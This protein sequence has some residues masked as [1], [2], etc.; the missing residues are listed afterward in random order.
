LSFFALPVISSVLVPSTVHRAHVGELR[1]VLERRGADRQQGRGEQW[2]RGILGAADGDLSYE[3]LAAFDDDLVHAWFL[4][5]YHVP[6]RNA[7]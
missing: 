1:D 4:R 3:A 7:A 2:Q 6:G 5:R